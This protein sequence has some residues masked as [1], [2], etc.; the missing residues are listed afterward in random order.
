M[1]NIFFFLT[2]IKICLLQRKLLSITI[3]ISKLLC[4]NLFLINGSSFACA[5]NQF[6][7]E[8]RH[9]IVR[10]FLD[11]KPFNIEY[12]V[13]R[14]KFQNNFLLLTILMLA[15]IAVAVMQLKM[16]ISHHPNQFT[17]TQCSINQKFCQQII[18]FL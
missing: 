12:L 7:Q 5:I 2:F 18:Y 14:K 15:F 16:M 11:I 17:S 6:N 4:Q 1:I 13:N 9:N 3:Y 10:G 8:N